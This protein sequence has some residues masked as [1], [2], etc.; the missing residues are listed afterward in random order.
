MDDSRNHPTHTFDMG[1]PTGV[2]AG[3]YVKS[4]DQHIGN[5]GADAIMK[6]LDCAGFE[7]VPK[8]LKK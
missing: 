1:R 6:M 5:D 8:E 3:T 4:W 7:I 2:I